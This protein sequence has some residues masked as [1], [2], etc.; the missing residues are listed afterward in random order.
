MVFFN[1][2]HFIVVIV[3]ND[4]KGT[5]WTS[6]YTPMFGTFEAEIGVYGYVEF[7]AAVSVSVVC[8]HWVTVFRCFSTSALANRAAPSAP[9]I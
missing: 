8:F 9:A 2:G 5:D 3:D 6:I 4:L 7:A 1:G